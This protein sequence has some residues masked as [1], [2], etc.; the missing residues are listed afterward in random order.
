MKFTHTMKVNGELAVRRMSEEA[1]RFYSETDP[2]S[3]YEYETDEGICYAYDDNVQ[4]IDGLTFED[5][6]KE[7]YDLFYSYHAAVVINGR[8]FD[9]SEVAEAIEYA[10]EEYGSDAWD[11]I[12]SFMDDDIREKVHIA[13]APCAETEFLHF[14]LLSADDDLY[15]M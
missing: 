12:V 11:V 8:R 7:L 10:N 1:Q 14:Y 2:F 5:I 3:V 9:A 4:I 15:V 13:C 6:D